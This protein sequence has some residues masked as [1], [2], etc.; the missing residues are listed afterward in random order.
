MALNTIIQM[1][2]AKGTSVT[3]KPPTTYEQVLEEFHNA[4][5][6]GRMMEVGMERPGYIHRFNPHQVVYIQQLDY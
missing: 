1:G 5:A 3:I 2:D 6:E 4:L